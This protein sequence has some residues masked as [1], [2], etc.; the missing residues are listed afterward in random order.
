MR[1][2]R[3]DEKLHNLPLPTLKEEKEIDFQSGDTV[4]ICAGF[5]DRTKKILEQIIERDIQGLTII[6]VLYQPAVTENKSNELIELCDKANIKTKIF[7]Y[8]R[9]N[10]CGAGIDIFH[11]IPEKKGNLWVDISGM[12]RL[13]IVQII[14]KLKEKEV[15]FSSMKIL[16]CEAEEYPPTQ[17]EV[18]DALIERETGDSDLFMF[19]STGVFEVSIV[20]ELS[21]ISLQGQPV[22]MIVFPSF[23]YDQLLALRILLQPSYTTIINGAPP[24]D[25]NHWRMEA[26][27]KLN[28][29]NKIVHTEEYTVSTLDYGET[30]KLITKIYANYGAFE[31]LVIAPIGSKMQTVGLALARLHLNDIQVVYPTPRSFINPEAYTRGV[32]T[33][34]SLDISDFPCRDAFIG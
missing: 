3:L 15:G 1:I 19:L 30:Y 18:S 16:Y 31:K 4:I 27:Y 24:S 8:D 17:S 5:E 11:K 26:I 12:S 34:Y 32:K 13:L 33:I 14:D 2:L 22:R 21:S 7:T 9:N 20:P 6:V 23:S 10:P 29:I 28:E 25:D